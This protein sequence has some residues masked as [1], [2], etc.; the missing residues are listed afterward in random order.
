MGTAEQIDYWIKSAIDD[1]QIAD[2]LISNGKILQGLFFSH[3]CIE[4]VIKAHFVRF[5][6]EI[7]PRSHNL[8]Y[9][10]SKTDLTL[11][12]DEKDL[13]SI[14]MTYQLEGR[15][16]EYYPSTPSMQLASEILLQ[17]KQLFKCLK[18]KL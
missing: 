7:P 12:E 15:Y 3:L 11:S 4:K 14:L 9:L 1:L 5:T 18:E 6:A 13:C 17:T 2:L 10:L 16:P 8:L